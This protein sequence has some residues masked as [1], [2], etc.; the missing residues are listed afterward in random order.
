MTH[1]V[2]IRVVWAVHITHSIAA[3]EKLEEALLNHTMQQL[4]RAALKPVK[5]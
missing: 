5:K 2:V 4:V 1:R 3:V